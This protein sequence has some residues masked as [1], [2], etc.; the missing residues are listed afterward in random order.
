MVPQDGGEYYSC[1]AEISFSEFKAENA[2][3]IV[4]RVIEGLVRTDVIPASD[5]KN[6]VSTWHHTVYYGYPTPSLERDAALA[7]VL[8]WLESHNIKSR[9]RFGLWRYEVA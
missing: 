3:D 7:L 9:G 2:S 8:P 1:M 4:E 6:I 5:R